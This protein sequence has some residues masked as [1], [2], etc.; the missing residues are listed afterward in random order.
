MWRRMETLTVRRNDMQRFVLTAIGPALAAVLL[1]PSP[2]QAQSAPPAAIRDLAPTGVLRVGVNFGNS[3]NASRD[4]ATG[5]L[6]GV[7]VDLARALAARLGVPLALVPYA[8]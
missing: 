4:P 5:E 1:I 3:N 2:A 7:A 8:G 6:R